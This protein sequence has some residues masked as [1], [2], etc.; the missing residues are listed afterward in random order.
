MITKE[1]FDK[2]I[3]KLEVTD[4]VLWDMSGQFRGD[5]HAISFSARMSKPQTNRDIV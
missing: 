4:P 1:E 2:F 3:D 5:H